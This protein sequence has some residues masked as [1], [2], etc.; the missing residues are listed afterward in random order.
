MSVV[1]AESF[2]SSTNT[3]IWA[4]VDFFPAVVVP[5]F[6]DIAIITCSQSFAGFAA[7]GRRL[8]RP[9]CHTQHILCHLSV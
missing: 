1:F 2:A 9:T 5:E 6:T 7:L 4:V 3:T 8:R